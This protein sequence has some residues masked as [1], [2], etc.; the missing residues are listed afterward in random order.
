MPAKRKP[1]SS[2]ATSVK[3]TKPNSLANVLAA[4]KRKLAPPLDSQLTPKQSAF[5]DEVVDTYLT[6][7]NEYTIRGL[8]SALSQELGQKITETWLY[9]RITSRRDGSQR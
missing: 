6:H 2:Q 5:V 1:A 8:A 3:I 4:G 7:P 9:K